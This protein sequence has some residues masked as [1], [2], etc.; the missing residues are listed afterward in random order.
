VAVAS[1]PVR[2]FAVGAPELHRLDVLAGRT[3]VR[4]AAADA[5]ARR[6]EVVLDAA[7]AEALGPALRA[8]ELRSDGSGRP[9]TVLGRLDADVGA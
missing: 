5:I 7:T 6:G 9:I 4:L 3:M 8:A 2:R 1:G